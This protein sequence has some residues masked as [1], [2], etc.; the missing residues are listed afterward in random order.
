MQH[1]LG[2]RAQRRN[3]TMYMEIG[4]MNRTLKE[5]LKEIQKLTKL[6]EGKSDDDK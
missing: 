2:Q 5:I 3:N 6:L 1:L 4:E